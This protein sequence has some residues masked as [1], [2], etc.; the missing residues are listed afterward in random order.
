[1]ASILEK[2]VAEGEVEEKAND[3]KRTKTETLIDDVAQAAAGWAVRHVPNELQASPDAPY[4]AKDS[5]SVESAA[6]A[7]AQLITWDGY[8]PTPIV[9]LKEVPLRVREI[10][11]V[12]SPPP[13]AR[14]PSVRIHSHSHSA[15]VTPLSDTPDVLV[16]DCWRLKRF[17][18][19]QAP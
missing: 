17:S 16:R 19:T 3:C 15:R 10:A 2:R 5:V 9:D 8:E 7:R 18:I 1:M 13:R 14:V 12:R 4:P 6:D 11:R